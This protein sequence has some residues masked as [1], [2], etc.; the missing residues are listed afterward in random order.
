MRTML[1][2]PVADRGKSE[3]FTGPSASNLEAARAELKLWHDAAAR[4]TQA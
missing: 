2:A 3:A 1:D 4:G